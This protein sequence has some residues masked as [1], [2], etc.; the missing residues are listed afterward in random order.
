MDENIKQLFSRALNLELPWQITRVHFN[1]RDPIF[2]PYEDSFEELRIDIGFQQE[3][4]PVLTC[5]NSCDIY[6]TF[7][8]RWCHLDF[9]HYPCYLYCEVPRILVGGHKRLIDVPWARKESSFTRLFERY[10]IS[11]KASKMPRDQIEKFLGVSPT[12][13]NELFNDFDY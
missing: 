10:A 1:T 2:Y 12:Q 3:S 6:D 7:S 4:K 8:V 9:L 11:L 5:G 13:F